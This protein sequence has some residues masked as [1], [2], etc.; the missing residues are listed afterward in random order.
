[1]EVTI[2][3]SSASTPGSGTLSLP[4]AI[5]M[6]FASYSV[7]STTS[8][9]GAVIRPSPLSQ[10]TLF[11]RNRNSTPFTL[12]LTTSPL[13]ACIRA[14]SSFTPSTLMPCSAK[15]CCTSW[16]FSEDCSSA[17]EGMQPTFRQVPPSVA[18]FSTQAV[19]SPSWAARMAHT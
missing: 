16:K 10:V 1:M 8:L 11:L 17:L 12:A 2:R 14:R 6:L 9:P 5:T 3:F 13:R 19:R 7:P 4:V 15:P 18:R